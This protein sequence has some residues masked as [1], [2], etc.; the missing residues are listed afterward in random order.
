MS[1]LLN[2]KGNNIHEED[3]N[4]AFNSACLAQMNMTLADYKK[5]G[6]FDFLTLDV[7]KHYIDYCADFFERNIVFAI[8]L[9]SSLLEL[10]MDTDEVGSKGKWKALFND[11]IE[12]GFKEIFCQSIVK[13]YNEIVVKYHIFN[14][15]RLNNVISELKLDE[16]RFDSYEFVRALLYARFY[17]TQLK[18]REDILAEYAASL[19]SDNAGFNVE[20]TLQ[21]FDKQCD[22]AVSNELID[23]EKATK[24]LSEYSE[25][26][27]TNTRVKIGSYFKDVEA[28][29]V[30]SLVAYTGWRASEYGFQESALKQVAN[31]DILDAVYTPYRFYVKW[32]S[33]K[34]NGETLLERE[35]TLSS[36][37]LIKQIANLTESK[38]NGFAL[39]STTLGENTEIERKISEMVSRHWQIFPDKYKTFIEIDELQL[40][41]AKGSECNFIEASKRQELSEKY[42]LNN[43][44]VKEIIELR[45][46]LRKDN[47]VLSLVS[48]K[49]VVNGKA[50]RF[51]ETLNRYTNGTLDEASVEI[52][53][54]RLSI[55]TLEY[56]KSASENLNK[57]NS[58]AIIDELLTGIFKATPHALRHVWAEAVLRR[59]KGDIGKFIRAN[60][61]HIDER[62]FMAYLRGKEARAIMQVAKRTTI[63]HIV[64][65]RIKSLTDERRHFSGQFDRFI[66]KAVVITNVHSPEEY[67]VLTNKVANDRVIDIKVNA[68]TTC[69]LRKG[70]YANAMCS[71]NGVPQRHKAAP[72]LC[73]GCINGDI[74]EG[75]YKGIVAYIKP[76]IEAC[77]NPKLPMFIKRP[78]LVTVRLALKRI[79]EL[80]K[81]Y[82][83]SRYQKFIDYLND[84]IDI[85]SRFE[86]AS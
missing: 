2:I 74:E 26:F 25:K 29:G 9:R 58:K 71:E 14:L 44:I 64:R 68:W 57:S 79:Q 36:H 75:N 6:T 1:S 73:L 53:E 49:Y 8:A 78:H 66:N 11:G 22:E 81:S 24:L 48:R 18:K 13:N 39:T 63:N 38:D 32:I 5:G 4:K 23:L 33:P 76:D 7:G 85:A 77:R 31:K 54:S 30:T 61:K 45:D 82:D 56:I 69:I 12:E 60:F 50:L 51:S 21:E 72:R 67:E 17:D 62:F 41:S 20:F 83:D 59:Y 70:T 28:A 34:T 19:N 47:Q 55:E 27:G 65:Y 15:D 84:T 16:T 52:L 80:S 10:G 42:D 43:R 40:L 37:I 46:K 35:I 86:E 3:L